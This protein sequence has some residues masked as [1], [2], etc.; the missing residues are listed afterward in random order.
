MDMNETHHPQPIKSADGMGGRVPNTATGPSSG[1]T[2]STTA[3]TAAAA[4]AAAAASTVYHHQQY[5][6]TPPPHN[7]ASGY[8]AAMMDHH[9]H[10]QMKDPYYHHHHGRHYTDPYAAIHHEHGGG[11]YHT[12]PQGPPPPPPPALGSMHSQHSFPHHHHHPHQNA[13]GHSYHHQPSVIYPGTQTSA[14]MHHHSHPIHH[15]SQSSTI[16]QYANSQAQQYPGYEPITRTPVELSPSGHYAGHSTTAHHH[17]VPFCTGEVAY[18]DDKDHSGLGLYGPGS[19][20]SPMTGICNTNVPSSSLVNPTSTV[21]PPGANSGSVGGGN[22]GKR[23]IEI[24]DNILIKKSKNTPSDGGL[25][26]SN[27]HSNHTNACGQPSGPALGDST[28]PSA[29]DSAKSSF[30]ISNI[31]DDKNAKQS[32]NTTVTFSTSDGANMATQHHMHIAGH[33][34]RA[35]KDNESS[36]YHH[37]NTGG[38]TSR[39]STKAS[40]SAD[41]SK[42]DRAGTSTNALSCPIS[43]EAASEQQQQTATNTTQHMDFDISEKL[44]EMGE[45]SVKPVSKTEAGTKSRTSELE[46]NE[47]IS[48]EITKKD[49]ALRK[50]TNLRK[51][52]KEVMDDNQLDASTLA[53]Q[54]QELERLA[55]VQEQ[56]RIIREVQRQLALE[57]QTNKTE[58][59]VMQF[60]QGHASILKSQQPSTSST[61]ATASGSGIT[62]TT[63]I[64]VGYVKNPFETRGRPPKNRQLLTSNATTSLLTTPSSLSSASATTNLTPS[65]SIA[66]VKASSLVSSLVGTSVSSAIPA[67]ASSPTVIPVRTLEEMVD[68]EEELEPEDEAE[69]EDEDSEGEVIAL[70]EKKEIVTIDSSSDDDCIVLS[71]DDE[72]PEDESDDD[73]QN[74]G[75]HV[76]DTYNVP[77]E[78]GRVVINVGHADGEDD[79]FLAPQIARI[80]KPHQIGGV[81][82]L[83]DNIIESIERY[84][85]STGFGCILAHS[86]GLGKTLQLVCFCDIFLRH[87]SSKTILIIMPINTLQN[88]LNEFNTWLPEDVENSSLRNH[89]DV[90]ARNFRIHILNDSHKTLKARSKVVL[91]WAK[92]GGVL[93]IGY[94][95]YRLLSQKKMTK[96]K[97][98][99]KGAILE[100]EKESTEEQRNMFDDIH[101]ALVKPGPDLVVCDEGHRI[102]NSHA[103]IS[104]ALKQIKSKRRVVLT[105]YPLQNNLLEYWCMVDFVRPNYLGTKTEFSNMFER[106]IQNGQCID[107]TPQDIKLMRYRAHVLHSLLLGFV[108]RRSHSVLQTSLPQKEEYVLLIRMTEF[109]RKLYSVFMNEVVRTKTVPNPLKAF[110]VCCKIWNHPDVLYNFLKQSERDLD[111]EL[112]ESEPAPIPGDGKPGEIPSTGI[113]P[114]TSG[115]VT[116]ME[117]DNG[118]VVGSVGNETKANTMEVPPTVSILTSCITKA[119]RKNAAIAK[120]AKPLALK[121]DGTPRKPR[122]SKKAALNNKSQVVGKDGKIVP[123]ATISPSNIHKDPNPVSIDTTGS[124]TV[125]SL[126]KIEAA[127]SDFGNDERL[128][129]QEADG[130][131]Y[132]QQPSVSQYPAASGI[133]AYPYQVYPGADPME[134][135]H[136]YGIYSQGMNN[137][138]RSDQANVYGNTYDSTSVRGQYSGNNSLPVSGTTNPYN[139][140]YGSNYYRNDYTN[141]YSQPPGYGNGATATSGTTGYEQSQYS[142][143]TN[144]AEGIQN[145]QYPNNESATQNSQ[146]NNHWSDSSNANNSIT[147]YDQQ[148]QQ[149]PVNNDTSDRASSAYPGYSTTYDTSNG[150]ETQIDDDH[151]DRS[152]LYAYPSTEQ[153]STSTTV[154]VSS[155]PLTSYEDYNSFEKLPENGLQ[156]WNEEQSSNGNETSVAANTELSQSQSSKSKANNK[157]VIPEPSPST[158]TIITSTE[159]TLET[160]KCNPDTGTVTQEQANAQYANQPS[161]EDLKDPVKPD[162]SGEKPTETVDMHTKEIRKLKVDHDIKQEFKKEI[163][164][165]ADIKQNNQ[166]KQESGVIIKSEIKMEENNGIVPSD[167]CSKMFNKSENDLKGVKSHELPEDIKSIKKEDVA[168]SI[169]IEEES[170][171]ASIDC[172]PSLLDKKVTEM[173][174]DKNP[175]ENEPDLKEYNKTQVQISE[176]GRKEKEKDVKIVL[177]TA[178]DKETPKD[179]SL[180]VEENVKEEK[181]ESS[182][183]GKDQSTTPSSY[184]TTTPLNSL[185]TNTAGSTK[186]GKGKD[187]KDEIP[188][189]WAFELMKGYIPDLLENSPKMEIFFCILEES[190]RL[191][192]RLLVFSQSLLTLNLIERFLQR[193]KIPGTE[194]HWSKN[195]SYFRL[196]GSTVAQEREKLINEFNSNPNVHL[197][198]VSTRAGSL[199]INLVG[200]NRVVVFDA[201][202][203][204]CHDT[205]AVCRVYRYGQKKPCFVYRLVMDNCLEKKIYDRQI[206]KQGMSDRIVDECNPDAHLSMKEITSLCYDDG[207]DGELK[208][209]SDEKDKFIDIVMQHLLE[210]H[211]KKLT[212]APFAHESLLIDRKEKKLSSAEKRQAQRGYE[213]EKQAATK[214]QYSYTSMGTTYRAIRTSDGSIIHR[215]VA[216]VRP[217]QAGDT[218]KTNV[219]GSRPT[220]W[221]PAEVWQRQGMTA[222]EM[223][224]PIDVVIPTSSADKSNIVL[225]AGQKVMVLK[226]PKGIYM[227]LESGKI[228]AIR[229]AFKVGQSKDA[230][231]A[232]GGIITTTPTSANVRK[233]SN[234]SFSSAKASSTLLVSKNGAGTSGSNTGDFSEGNSLSIASNSDDDEKSDS[235]ILPLTIND[236]GDSEKETM[237]VDDYPDKPVSRKDTDVEHIVSDRTT[238]TMMSSTSSTSNSSGITV[239]VPTT[240]STTASSFTNASPAKRANAQTSESL[241]K[242]PII[243]SAYSLA[244]QAQ[245]L[246]SHRSSSGGLPLYASPST[247]VQSTAS[248]TI[249]D[250]FPPMREKLTYKP[251]LVERKT[252]A[253]P[254]SLKNYRHKASKVHE[255]NATN[256]TVAPTPMSTDVVVSATNVATTMLV[257]HSSG[258]KMNHDIPSSKANEVTNNNSANDAA[259]GMYNVEASVD[260]IGGLYHPATM[261]SDSKVPVCRSNNNITANS[262]VFGHGVGSVGYSTTPT[263]ATHSDNKLPITRTA[264]S[265]SSVTMTVGSEQYFPSHHTIPSVPPTSYGGPTIPTTGSLIEKNQGQ[266]STTVDHIGFP[267]TSNN[268]AANNSTSKEHPP[269]MPYG[270]SIGSSG[271]GSTGNTITS[272]YGPLSQQQQQMHTHGNL[273]QQPQHDCQSI[274][275]QMQHRLPHQ[276]THPQHLGLHQNQTG[277]VQSLPPPPQY[278]SSL[279]FLEKTTSA[280][281]NN[282][283]QSEFQASLSNITRSPTPT[284]GYIDYNPKTAVAST[285]KVGAGSKNKTPKAPKNDYNAAKKALNKRN[286]PSPYTHI[287]SSSASSSPSASPAVTQ[288]ATT[289]PVSS[290]AVP[291]IYHSYHTGT[292]TGP[293]PAIASVPPSVTA[294]IHPPSGLYCDQYSQPTNQHSQQLTGGYGS[295]II[296]GTPPST[297]SSNNGHVLASQPATVGGYGNTLPPV[298]PFTGPSYTSTSNSTTSTTTVRS[299]YYQLMGA[300]ESSSIPAGINSTPQPTTMLSAETSATAYSQHSTTGVQ[301]H[302]RPTSPSNTVAPHYLQPH[303]ATGSTPSRSGNARG[304]I[305]AQQQQHLTHNMQQSQQQQQHHSQSQLHTTHHQHLPPQHTTPVSAVL[306]DYSIHAQSAI[307]YASMEATPTPP[308]TDVGNISS[309]ALSN[310]VYHQQH[311][312][313]HQQPLQHEQHQHLQHPA[314]ASTPGCFIQYSSTP[315]S[316]AGYGVPAVAVASQNVTSTNN[317]VGCIASTSSGSTGSAANGSAFHRPESAM[318]MGGTVASPIVVPPVSTYDTPPTYIPDANAPTAAYHQYHHAPY[319]SSQYHPHQP[320]SYYPPPPPPPSSSYS[321]YPSSAGPYGPGQPPLTGPGIVPTDSQ[322]HTYP[323]PPPVSAAAPATASNYNYPPYPT[324]P[325]VGQWQ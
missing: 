148:Q 248:V 163:D 315:S 15:P 232:K 42:T 313:S 278:E 228:I 152:G 17:N 260:S 18:R 140:S 305:A 129:K 63:P 274:G 251:N 114:A 297:S 244:P 208:D 30:Q 210:T 111:L 220:R 184:A 62:T 135:N 323:P 300:T 258:S 110:A 217:M 294:G 59:K 71:D 154:D 100:E 3:A 144:S 287:S 230:P 271:P 102:K 279:N 234:L 241:D 314:V 306:P 123:A 261:L 7:L 85:S 231:S 23:K 68:S 253:S 259:V 207:E 237:S 269:W 318:A 216:S 224:L 175:T 209:F 317:T 95:M 319:Q 14:G 310:N 169:E 273:S 282:Q 285:K 170:E 193:N 304:S 92:N 303:V 65:V 201:S 213:L 181:S 29:G 58:Q 257:S 265:S 26:K 191:G 35:K 121:K 141:S 270:S 151:N 142:Y 276:T 235:S 32:L 187:P 202:W 178:N 70:P 89:G 81:R 166:I 283:N 77:D 34:E 33:T 325:G 73:P 105:G 183:V 309:N 11:A 324:Q 132:P 219:A 221:I 80:I 13:Y 101:E 212:K 290:T 157:E 36:H 293:S 8:A 280:L 262:D 168:K 124:P 87:T 214:P 200:A 272:H 19:E 96:K 28:H 188:Y 164:T 218:N 122:T 78:Q 246:V 215:P 72:E 263:H 147:Y 189:E 9:H 50:V 320:Q 268:S 137:M 267:S 146:P 195:S 145:L 249:D 46:C 311:H 177:K 239:P 21:I 54:R 198:L 56:Q 236:D 27:V 150:N 167:A 55:R 82:F 118:G 48:L 288:N 176:E 156:K 211:S 79:I 57:R 229:T 130:H 91:E 298:M 179:D 159:S 64:R 25:T 153:Q 120:P 192:D 39:K 31:L 316:T 266:Q 2:L 138:I 61:I 158:D 173:V 226:S 160:V 277:G 104:V 97:K 44:K 12:T 255:I 98:K 233:T 197:F 292:G 107:S 205:Q 67:C 161:L 49:A 227:Q 196:D 16:G 69:D 165:E 116:P 186:E 20:R 53:A 291:S 162:L 296:I 143:G 51:N 172:T 40:K 321:Y 275:S 6:Q 174:I 47:E 301:S 126:P 223:T 76:N 4:A 93:L 106:P 75:L 103:S 256:T 139:N 88:W 60:L 250:D 136:T 83:F 312:P 108:Q 1:T 322:Y 74:S 252:K 24:L 131:M 125:V 52:I 86:M 247:T 203:N 302:H 90:R 119:G 38:S 185:T 10:H 242:F 180:I 117:I 299:N 222:Q 206:N 238:D 171:K 99:K 308:N 199:G 115:S 128:V 133:G 182:A 109:Q 41:F 113:T 295:N 240:T 264:T 281:I 243:Q 225:K 45:I 127:A 5:S 204:P 22:S 37:I 307:P 284:D 84:D 254:S 66:P 149:P 190:I 289:A 155:Q 286:N 43:P 134:P 194:N 245:S 112:E 94:E